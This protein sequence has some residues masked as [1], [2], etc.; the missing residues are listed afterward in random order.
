MDRSRYNPRDPALGVEGTAT[1][2]RTPALVP[3]DDGSEQSICPRCMG[4]GEIVWNPSDVRDPQ[5]ERPF[6]CPDCRGAGVKG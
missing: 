2:I 5:Y 3:L 6:V 1:G 4:A